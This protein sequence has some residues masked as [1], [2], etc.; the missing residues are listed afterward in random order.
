MFLISEPN[1]PEKSGGEDHRGTLIHNGK[2]G[3][4]NTALRDIISDIIIL[5]D[6]IAV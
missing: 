6:I 5:D 3:V 4:N 2:S 1:V